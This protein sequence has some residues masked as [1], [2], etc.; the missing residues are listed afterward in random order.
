[1]MD[2]VIA[3]GGDGRD[4]RANI[5]RC[6]VV[7]SWIGHLCSGGGMGSVELPRRSPLLPNAMKAYTTD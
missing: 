4:V 7:N 2:D 1:M 5:F 6:H 3:H